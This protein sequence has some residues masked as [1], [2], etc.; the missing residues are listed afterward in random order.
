MT[1]KEAKE[2][3]IIQWVGPG[4]A[5]ELIRSQQTLLARLLWVMRDTKNTESHTAFVL[6][7]QRGQEML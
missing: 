6:R 5:A 4:W 7:N 2:A 3:A 1:R